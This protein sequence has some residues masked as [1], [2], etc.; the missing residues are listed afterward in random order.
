MLV[1]GERLRRLQ[2]VAV[3]I[4]AVAV[5]AL[6]V[7]YGRPPWIALVLA[8][9]FGSYGLVKKLAAVG[10]VEALSVETGVMFLPALAFL[11]VLQI[12][13]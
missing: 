13:R 5:L 12:L 3:G 11:L 2:W 7:D 8:V 4:G 9:S 6:A 1:L 10:A